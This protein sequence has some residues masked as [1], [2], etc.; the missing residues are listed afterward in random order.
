MARVRLVHVLAHGDKAEARRI[1]GDIQQY[2]RLLVGTGTWYGAGVYA[3]DPDHL[4]A[5]LR[6]APQVVFEVDESQIIR[7]CR[8][9]GTWLG[10]VRI[11]GQIGDYVRI[12]VVA[13][14]NLS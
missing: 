5:Q 6:R 12:E 8:R 3:W 14:A 4:P 7:V 10:F 1:A 2:Q 9:D 13:F 11:P